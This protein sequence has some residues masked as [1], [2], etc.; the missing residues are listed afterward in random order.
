MNVGDAVVID[1]KIAPSSFYGINLMSA[2]RLTFLI[3]AI[4]QD[5]VCIVISMVTRPLNNNEIWLLTPS[6]IIGWT[7][8]SDI[9]R[10]L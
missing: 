10:V 8:H 3:H 2:D 7:F 9:F 1:E 4:K 6:G 5:D